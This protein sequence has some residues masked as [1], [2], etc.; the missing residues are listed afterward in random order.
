MTGA[1][2]QFEA[3]STLADIRSEGSAIAFTRVSN[4]VDATDRGTPTP[5]IIP[6]A[7]M[8]TKGDPATYVKLKLEQT[9][10]VTVLFAPDVAGQLPEPGDKA[11]WANSKFTVADVDPVMPDGVTLVYARIVMSR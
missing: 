5:S 3:L 8:R 1:A 6:G 11:R 4:T 7:A 2:H 9:K 10:A